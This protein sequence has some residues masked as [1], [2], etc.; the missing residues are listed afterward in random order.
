[1]KASP[2]VSIALMCCASLLHAQAPTYVAAH[3]SP[4][5][6]QVLAIY[7]G[8][9][10]CAPCVW[11]PLKAAVHAAWP[12]LAKQAA[13]AKVGFATLGIAM[14]DDVTSGVALLQPVEE[15]DEIIVGAGWTNH[16]VTK[17]IW[18]DS[19]GSPSI[20]QMMV[21]QRVA[22]ASA[23]WTW[24]VTPYKVLKRLVGADE[25]RRWVANG[26]R[27]EVLT[28]EAT[29]KLDAAGA[30]SDVATGATTVSQ[31]TLATTKA[32]Q[33]QCARPDSTSTVLISYLRS[34]AQH[35]FPAVATTA[36]RSTSDVV[37]VLVNDRCDV[38]GS[39]I[40][41]RT[42][43]SLDVGNTIATQFPTADLTRFVAGGIADLTED[44]AGS[45]GA[46]WLVWMMV[47]S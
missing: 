24:H 12:L 46:P 8:S 38:L 43:D 37:V 26:A 44:S 6:P 10:D 5:G 15:Y 22:S 19:T 20:P 41:S 25:I 33:V 34:V 47:K 16:G 18:Q 30:P 39:G 2:S 17:Y 42:S 36:R 9:T 28:P 27:I 23:D 11:P 13:D 32:S 21:I 14:D 1:M 35:A 40:V 29:Q 4:N 3:V 7:M 31:P 45:K